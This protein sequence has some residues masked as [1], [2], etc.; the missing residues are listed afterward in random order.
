M[1]R[2]PNRRLIG[3]FLVT[4]ILVFAVVMTMFI[5]QKFFGGSGNMLVMYFDESIKG[6]NVGS[7]VVFK[8]VEI[9][10][11]AKIDLI[12][13]ANNLDFSIPVYA[14]MEDYQGIHTRERPEDDK[15]E[16]LDAL[17]KK[18]L[19]ARLTAQNYLTGQ[20]VIELEMLPD[21]PIELRYRGHDKD[22]LEIPTVL[23]PMG[24]ISKGIQ[25]IPIRESVEKFNRFFD[26]MNK[27]IP[28]VMPQISYTFKNL[29]KAVKD[30]AEVSADTFDNLNQA[31]AN[32]GEASKAFRNFA[33]YVERHPE[34]LL[35]GKRGN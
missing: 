20:L 10:K 27:Q 29:N 2:E 13:D 4:G 21:T 24:E 22:V 15:R 14:K 16:I 5:R 11:V 26:E 7:S 28:I 33:D 9:G 18:G 31:I 23:S 17:I 19:R 30:N 12:A 3:I 6:L 35:K 32:F 25:N 34:A 1:H 8:G